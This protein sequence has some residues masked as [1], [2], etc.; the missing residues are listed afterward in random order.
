[1]GLVLTVKIGE[2]QCEE[3]VEEEDIPEET[4]HANPVPAGLGEETSRLQHLNAQS[5]CAHP[6]VDNLKKMKKVNSI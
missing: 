4:P 5:L 2:R 1:M 3:A 6:D